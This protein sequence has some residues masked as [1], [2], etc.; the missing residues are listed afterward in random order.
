MPPQSN[1]SSNPHEQEE[2]T[3]HLS[4]AH[5]RSRSTLWPGVERAFLKQ[6]PS[7]A[8]CESRV[9]LNVHHRVPFSYCIPL[10]RP[11]LEFDVRNLVTLCTRGSDHHLLLGHLDLF[12]S[13][14]P[15]L[16]E[17]IQTFTSKTADDIRKDRTW[18]AKVRERPPSYAHMSEQQRSEL[19]AYLATRFPEQRNTRRTMGR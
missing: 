14:N 15:T 17:D 19:R 10:G 5:A 13:Y 8:V 12:A 1:P 6:H 3:L 2:A 9:G 16:E 7:C 18:K 4:S 11:D